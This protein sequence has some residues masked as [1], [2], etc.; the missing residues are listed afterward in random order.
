MED[1]SIPL[2]LSGRQFA[3][4][5]DRGRLGPLQHFLNPFCAEVKLDVDPQVGGRKSDLAPVAGDVRDG[6][7][8]K[9]ELNWSQAGW[10]TRGA[11]AVVDIIRVVGR[12]LPE[13]WLIDGVQGEDGREDLRRES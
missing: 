8:T 7:P 10:R 1:L 5:R 6:D 4:V 3:T 9:C 13:R 12:V 2:S 11:V